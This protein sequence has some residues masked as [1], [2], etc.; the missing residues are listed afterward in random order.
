MAHRFVRSMLLR[1]ML[2]ESEATAVLLFLRESSYSFT[3]RLQ[4]VCQT[5]LNV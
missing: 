3:F 2:V 5:C 4:C 1:A